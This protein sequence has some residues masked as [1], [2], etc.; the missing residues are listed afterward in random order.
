[1]A[2]KKTSTAVA[3][4]KSTS[5][6]SVQE[7]MAKQLEALQG[8]TAPSSGIKV[9]ATQDK[10][11]LLPDG[12]KTPGPIDV[13]ILDFVSENV[14]YEGDFDRN[15]ITPPNCFA[16][17]D[18]PAQLAPSP[19]SPDKQGDE[20]G[21]CAGCAMN[22]WGSG[23]NGGKACKNSR[24]LAVIQV[25]EDTDP[26][27]A[28]IWILQTSPTAIKGFDAYVKTVVSTFKCPP[29]GVITRVGF[30][31]SQT[32]TTFVFGDPVPNED[33]AACFG[34]IEEARKLLMEEP[35]VSGFG[36]PKPAQKKAAPARRPA[37]ARR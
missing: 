19:N 30:D 22:A 21:A 2:T 20:D 31:E 28:P 24:K 18:I 32:Y 27:T 8:K 34:R 10:Q 15:N 7:M 12:T 3:V 6:V 4:P 11:M 16:I 33:V 35:D 29:A 13:V 17:G 37:T 1:M 5:V 14:W 26:A 25:T 23:K 9:R 36:A